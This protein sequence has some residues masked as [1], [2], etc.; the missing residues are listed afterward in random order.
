MKDNT[1]NDML[2]MQMYIQT[3]T[4]WLLIFVEVTLVISHVISH[5]LNQISEPFQKFGSFHLTNGFS[6]K[7]STIHMW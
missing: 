3:W 1:C 5:N 7:F 2:K 6:F 4:K